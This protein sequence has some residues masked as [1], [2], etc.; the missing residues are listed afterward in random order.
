MRRVRILPRVG[1][2][3]AALV[4]LDLALSDGRLTAQTSGSPY[5]MILTPERALALLQASDRKLPYVPGEVIVKFKTGVTA[6]GQQRALMALRSRPSVGSL[7]WVGN[8]AVLTDRSEPDATILA[9][10]LRSQPEVASAEPNY[11]RRANARPNDPGFAPRQWNLTAL[12]MPTVWDINP[13]GKAD[14][15]VAIVDTGITTVNQSFTFRTWN[16]QAIQSVAVPYAVNPDLGASRIINPKDFVFWTGPVLDMVGH[17]THVASTI[18]EETNNAVAEAGIAY[19]VKIMPVK[20]CVGSWEVQFV[21]SAAGYRGFV[22]PDI[23]GCDSA[24]IVEGIRYAAD[25]GAKVINLSLGSEEPSTA[26][27]DALTYAIGKGAF[28]SIAAGNSYEEGNAVAYPAGSATTIDGAMSVGALGPSLTRS[29]YSNTGP[30]L[31]ISAPGGN[32]REGGTDGMIWQA[33]ILISD[34]DPRTVILPRFDRYAEVAF[35]GTSMAAPHISGIAAL[36][37]SQ[38]VTKPA[39]VEALIKATARDLG[40]PG[41]DAE[42]GYGL[43]QPRNA[44]IGFGLGKA[45]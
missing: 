20:V 10:R 9:A 5:Q 34:S 43:V 23:G 42:Y 37:I 29:Y 32:D 8:V 45:K 25:N 38:G 24:A 13:G 6:A 21:L 41:R 1:S 36:I 31:E 12:D 39:G 26:E 44:L 16:G 11:L 17:G 3:L 33:T 2:V 27:N 30:H 14:V 15:V 22:P 19:K 7:R 35:E 40:A 28:I 4:L 18:G